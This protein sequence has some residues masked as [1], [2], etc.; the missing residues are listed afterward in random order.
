MKELKTS[1]ILTIPIPEFSSDIINKIISLFY[2]RRK[3]V[4]KDFITNDKIDLNTYGIYD[5]QLILKEL[6][7]N[8]KLKIDD[9]INESK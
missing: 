5:L 1:Q 6:K 9:I 7:E 8:L 4:I 2:S 3:F